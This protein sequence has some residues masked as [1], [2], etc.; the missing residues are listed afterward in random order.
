MINREFFD[1]LPE[2]YQQWIVEADAE[3][4]DYERKLVQEEEEASYKSWIENGGTV[5]EVD[6]NEWAEAC[7][8]VL[9]DYEDK[10][11]MEFVN[12]LRGQ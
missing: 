5:T 1:E 7:S 12:A 10:L 3:A 9:E 4:R 6:M 2:E 11:N 8:F